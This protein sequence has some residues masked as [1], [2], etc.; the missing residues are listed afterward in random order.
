MA[1]V[2]ACEHLNAYLYGSPEFTV[3]TDH[4]P[5]E[6]IWTK[7]KPTLWIERWGLRLQPYKFKIKYRSGE[8]NTADYLSRHPREDNVSSGHEEKVAE[9][10][11][12][13][14]CE[15]SIPKAMSLDEIK[16]VRGTG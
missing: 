3:I 13:F 14:I 9:Y 5:L 2:W 11:V 16:H 4:K 8:E 15:T 1:V 10:Y 6:K 12:N 7:P